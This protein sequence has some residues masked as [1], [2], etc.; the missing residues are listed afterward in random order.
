MPVPAAAGR[1][2]G[3]L[4]ASGMV[5]I[6]LA[7]LAFD[8]PEV[9][10]VTAIARRPLAGE[11]LA[12]PKLREV[13]HDDFLDFAPLAPAIAGAELWFWCVGVY[14][15]RASEAEFFRVTCDAFAAFLRA[16]ESA[17]PDATLC[18]FS[19]QGADP[20]ERSR[21]LFA[22]AK[23]RA[24]R[25]LAES[26]IGSR[27]VFRPGYIDP[28]RKQARSRIPV[29]FAR[30]FYRLMPFLGIDAVDLAAVMLD[31]ALHG[32]ERNLYETRDLRR[33]AALLRRGR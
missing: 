1:H 12:H 7:H 31:A 23:G 27:F 28:G 21:L 14:T 3:I 25:L 22:R 9:A 29:W 15:G 32:S 8:S 10:S 17:R 2:V 16:L 20:T 18:L 24:E 11:G 4:G 6:E 13:L 33:A 5:G 26:R 19:A 30:P